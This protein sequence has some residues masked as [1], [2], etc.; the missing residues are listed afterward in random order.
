MELVEW[1]VAVHHCLEEADLGHA[2]GGALALGY[3]A[4]PRGTVDVDVN[5]FVPRT[6]LDRV[7]AALADLGLR[8][9][10][11]GQAAPIAGVRFVHAVDPFPVDVFLSLDESYA[12]VERRVVRHPFGRGEDVLPFL[13]PED[14]CVF[15]L[16]FGRPKDW[17][18]LH[19]IAA[20]GFDLD[21]AYIEEQLLGL[22]GPTMHPRLARFRA[23]LDGD[24]PPGG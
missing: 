8:Q 9:E 11:A 7:A 1:I 15:K 23:M 2:F 12:R 24:Q 17:A 6:E 22:R 18:D 10:E 20:S 14:L 5:V 21:T 4:D 16:S 19:A 3:V 13:S